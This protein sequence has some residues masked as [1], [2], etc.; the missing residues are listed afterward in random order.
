MPCMVSEADQHPRA[1]SCSDSSTC[2]PFAFRVRKM[3]R[4][5]WNRAALPEEFTVARGFAAGLLYGA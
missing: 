4:V 5:S 1:A 2:F 3:E